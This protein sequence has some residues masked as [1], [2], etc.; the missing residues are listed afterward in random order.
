[1]A[2]PSTKA[3]VSLA[4]AK[5]YMNIS[6]AETDNDRLLDALVTQAC[7]MIQKELGCDI[8]EMDYTKEVHSGRGHKMLALKN[9]P[10]QWV[11]RISVDTDYALRLRYTGTG[12]RA[13][14]SVTSNSIRLRS[15]TSGVWTTDAL[16]M[17]DSVTMDLMALTVSGVT[18][19][20][21]TVFSTYGDF[22]SADLIV[23][24]AWDARNVYVD[25]EIPQECEDDYE[26]YDADQA[27]LYNPYVWTAGRRN[28]F[29][30]YR[31]GY[32]RAE[33]PEPIQ[34]AALELVKFLFDLAQKDASLKS[35]AIGDYKYSIADRVGAI[36]SVTG[37]QQV[38]NMISMK[39]APY[40]REYIRGF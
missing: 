15:V 40:Q 26:I 1:M 17:S 3:L 28:I 35:E 9:Y 39:L 14:A 23:R 6:T 24:P 8:I 13:T 37:K 25:L 32:A 22:A 27:L 20:E 30:D 19:W 33:I 12:S 34:A 4:D 38:S 2:I 7:V 5:R 31:A 29:V 36:F 10:L 21:G 18:D 11:N 16:V